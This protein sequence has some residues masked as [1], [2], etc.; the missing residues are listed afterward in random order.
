MTNIRI[1]DTDDGFDAL[2]ETWNRLSAQMPAS[3]FASFDFVRTAW[4]HFRGR[5]DR[6]FLLVLSNGATVYGIAPFYIADCRRRGIRYRAIRFIASREGDR[7]QLVGANAQGESLA[8]I[9]SFLGGGFRD[10]GVIELSE[11]PAGGPENG[12]WSFLPR[13]GWYWESEPDAVDYYISL[14]GSWEDYLGSRSANTRKNWRKLNRRLS[15]GPGGFSLERIDEPSLA[16]AALSRFVAIEQS[17]W[18]AGAKIGAA[19]DE[20]HRRF[21]EDLVSRLAGK[22]QVVFHFLTAGG[23]DVAGMVS[24]ICRDVIY[25]RHIAYLPDH[26]ASSPGTLLLTETIRESFAGPFRE[27]DMLGMKEDASAHNYKVHWATGRRE[28]VRMTG[29]RVWSRLLPLIMAKQ[30]KRSLAG[31]RPEAAAAAGA[32]SGAAPYPDGN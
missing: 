20:R 8:E 15:A 13:S 1:V 25:A 10:W 4:S 30:L 26:A 28:T 16:L 14:Q 17:S 22:G 3:F 27:F 2:E 9:L 24:F 31:W 32:T 11:Q 18:K 5:D 6:L 12:G 7:P 23:E 19:K 29:S 21:Y